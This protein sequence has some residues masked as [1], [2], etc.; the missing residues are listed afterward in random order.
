MIDD[1]KFTSLVGPR[2]TGNNICIDAREHE[3]SS[4][5]ENLGQWRQIIYG[6]YK[7]VILLEMY[8]LYSVFVAYLRYATKT[9][10]WKDLTDKI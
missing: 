5:Q 4:D 8:V 7:E 1:E 10:G 9:P 3:R 6:I 2:W